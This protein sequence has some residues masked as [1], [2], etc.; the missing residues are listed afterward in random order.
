ML[1]AIAMVA[2][3]LSARLPRLDD[4]RAQDT[5][6]YIIIIGVVT[7]AVVLAMVTP[8]GSSLISAVAS[9]TC[10]AVNSLPNFTISC[11]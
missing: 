4:E 2:S 8:V 9:G 11:P 3:Y 7:V 6:E 5:F 1:Q 10:N